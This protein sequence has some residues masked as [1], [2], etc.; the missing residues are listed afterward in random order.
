MVQSSESRDCLVAW[1]RG[2][3]PLAFWPAMWVRPLETIDRVINYTA[4]KGGS[5]MDA[6]SFFLG[7]SSA[8][9]GPL[10]YPVVLLLRLS[11]V[12]LAGILALIWWKGGRTRS[13]TL[14]LLAGLSFVALALSVAPKKA[15]RYIIPAIPIV[16]TLAGL[17]MAEL[18]RRGS[19]F[20]VVIP[21]LSLATLGLS[22]IS[23][24]PYPLAYYNPLLGGGAAASRL[25]LVGWGEGL[26]QVAAYLNA[27]EDASNL[28]AAVVYPDALDAQFTGSVVPL[29][30]YDVADV[31]VRYV[32]ADQRRLTPPAL[33][34]GSISSARSSRLSSTASRTPRYI[35]YRRRS[36]TVGS[37]STPL[38]STIDQSVEVIRWDFPSVGGKPYLQLNRGAPA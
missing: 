3:L 2:H 31:A 30:A 36:L 15:D 38:P 16:V 35:V 17:G 23:V 26:D 21:A 28:T 32:A 25:V 1:E 29:S 18:M 6:G 9:P 27:Q 14:L 5:P 11:P 34:A 13:L 19:R 22:L 20:G 12:A 7:T 4:L 10:F 24:R 8:D 37:H 33:D